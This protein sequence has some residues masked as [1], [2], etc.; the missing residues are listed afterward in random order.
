MDSEVDMPVPALGGVDP[1]HVTQEG[2]GAAPTTSSGLAA[3]RAAVETAATRAATIWS[4][5]ARGA[6]RPT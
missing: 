5:L 2:C 4:A 3:P 1:V 6:T